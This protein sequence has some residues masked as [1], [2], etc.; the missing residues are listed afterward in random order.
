MSIRGPLYSI[1]AILAV[2]GAAIVSAT[3]YR[4]GSQAVSGWTS[5]VA[6]GPLSAKH[7]FLSGR[8]E[9]CHTPVKGVDAASCIACHA[10]SAKE[11]GKQSTVFHAAAGMQCRGCHLEHTGSARPTRM[12]HASLLQAT[13]PSGD[14][15]QSARIFADQVIVDLK[16]FVGVPKSE[17]R[18]KAEL[19]CAGCHGNREP[20]RRLFGRECGGCH[21]LGSWKIAGFL[22]PS[23]TSK[24]CAQCHQAPPSHYME[25]F[26]MMDRMIT[27]QEHASVDQC[28]LCH[29]TDSFNDIRGIGW[30]KHH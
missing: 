19:D 8:C 26:V 27:G 7:A 15:E 29:R 24:D 4:G 17:G 20:H 5:V 16:E 21:E 28:Y 3:V 11:L 18:E 6:P 23:P 30:M 12:D 22:H 10:P 14:L 2:V 1:V 9:D 13:R 25:H